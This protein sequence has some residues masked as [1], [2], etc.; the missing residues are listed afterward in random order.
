MANNQLNLFH[1]F[2][3]WTTIQGEC[4]LSEEDKNRPMLCS[5]SCI[6]FH[7]LHRITAIHAKIL[8]QHAGKYN[9]VSYSV[10]ES[11]KRKCL[12]LEVNVKLVST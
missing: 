11:E 4:C 3:F 10:E 8:L 1:L 6:M 2:S 12:I 5:I 7:L 9:L